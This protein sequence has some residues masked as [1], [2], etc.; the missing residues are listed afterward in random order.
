MVPECKGVGPE[1]PPINSCLLCDTHNPASPVLL[2]LGTHSS[3]DSPNRPVGPLP[4]T[5]DLSDPDPTSQL[6]HGS[7]S[8]GQ[9]Q[10]VVMLLLLCCGSTSATPEMAF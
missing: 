10:H 9:G 3:T 6:T 4:D 8:E 1:Q 2:R 5:P 7:R